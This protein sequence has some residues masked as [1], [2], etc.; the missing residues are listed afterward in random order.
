[1]NYPAKHLR[2]L[3]QNV[4]DC[5][6][7]PSRVPVVPVTVAGAGTG[8]STGWGDAGALGAVS[9]AVSAIAGSSSSTPTLLEE[10]QQRAAEAKRY[11][12]MSPHDLPGDLKTE[13][14]AL[15][16]ELSDDLD[17]LGAF[18]AD[19]RRR[20]HL[21]TREEHIAAIYAIWLAVTCWSGNTVGFANMAKVVVG[22]G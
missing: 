19:L 22:K 12:A 3:V 2:I 17:A 14:E 5:S 8:D 6:M 7:V 20:E 9:A 16:V 4:P 21:L 13:A 1:M 15:A 10:L 18:W 11:L